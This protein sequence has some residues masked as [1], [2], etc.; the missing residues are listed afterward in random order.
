MVFPEVL[1][2]LAG[3]G[4]EGYLVDYRKETTTYFLPSGE[5]VELAH[6]DSPGPAVAGEFRAR[7]VEENVRKSQAN[8][9]TYKEFSAA[10]REAGCAGYIVSLLGKRVTYFGRTGETHVELMPS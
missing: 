6:P 10:V 9:H 1:S 8:L 2:T 5:F 3:A 7:T 4:I